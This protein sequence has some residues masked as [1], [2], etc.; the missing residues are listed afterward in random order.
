M[1]RHLPE[2]WDELFERCPGSERKH[3]LHGNLLG[4]RN[5]E[6]SGERK[7]SNPTG[8]KRSRIGKRE[9][10]LFAEDPIERPVTS[11]NQQDEKGNHKQGNK[12]H[13]VKGWAGCPEKGG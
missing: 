6:S 2:F 13:V 12:L 4:K 9:V 5:E 11:S 10:F 1:A 8:E 3:N 7:Q